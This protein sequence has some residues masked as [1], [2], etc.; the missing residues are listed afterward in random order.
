VGVKTQQK[1]MQTATLELGPCMCNQILP[2]AFITDSI[3]VI[4][5]EQIESDIASARETLA[6]A[7]AGIDKMR[8]ELLSL[9]DKVAKGKVRI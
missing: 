8:Q 7:S 4:N 1:E 9:G 5:T 6:D 3:F 2:N